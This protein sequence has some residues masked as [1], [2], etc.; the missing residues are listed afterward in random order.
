LPQLKDW[1]DLQFLI[2]V[3]RISLKGNNETVETRFF[4]SSLPP[5]AEH[6]GKII[7]GH[8]GIENSLQWQLDIT[9]R[10]DLSRVR[11]KIMVEKIYLS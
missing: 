1:A 7:R 6:Q 4:I 10:E 3:R 11:K 2:A 9:F 5:E 8:W